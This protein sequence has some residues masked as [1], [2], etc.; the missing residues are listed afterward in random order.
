MLDYN[1]VLI[2]S[3]IQNVGSIVKPIL[4]VIMA[5]YDYSISVYI[6]LKNIAI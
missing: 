1:D 3:V 2:N 4:Y 5:L 6:S